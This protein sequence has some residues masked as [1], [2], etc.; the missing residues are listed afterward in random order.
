MRLISTPK[1]PHSSIIIRSLCWVN[2]GTGEFQSC[3]GNYK[4]QPEHYNIKSNFSIHNRQ[5]IRIVTVLA[6]ISLLAS[7]TCAKAS[8]H[9]DHDQHLEVGRHTQRARIWISSHYSHGVRSIYIYTW[10]LFKLGDKQFRNWWDV[11]KHGPKHMGLAA[12]KKNMNQEA[13]SIQFLYSC[14]GDMPDCLSTICCA[15]HSLSGGIVAQ[16]STNPQVLYYIWNC[17]RW[18]AIFDWM[19]TDLWC[20]RKAI[21]WK[22][23]HAVNCITLFLDDVI[24]RI[25]L[26]TL[27]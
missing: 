13:P 7:L 20:L 25:K 27:I 16:L 23:N 6:Q 1:Q 12:L 4:K 3:Q 17:Q 21:H 15:F 24:L 18:H 10:Q 26:E 22:N 11:L 19:T 5:V 2:L 9:H 14:D 8:Q